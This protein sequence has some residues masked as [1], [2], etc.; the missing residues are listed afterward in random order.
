M[1]IPEGTPPS[2]PETQ[3]AATPQRETYLELQR[4]VG[5]RCEMIDLQGGFDEHDLSVDT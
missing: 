4:R 3:A 1:R 5:D 2:Q